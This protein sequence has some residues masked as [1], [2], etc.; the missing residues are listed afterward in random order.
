MAQEDDDI[1]RHQERAKARRR[2]Y[3]MRRTATR[4]VKERGTLVSW[5]HLPDNMLLGEVFRRARELEE[6][7][8]G[9]ANPDALALA[10]DV[11]AGLAELRLRGDQLSLF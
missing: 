5:A 3:H 6:E 8:S 7:L 1:I 10:Q 2:A 4:K 11:S 9:W